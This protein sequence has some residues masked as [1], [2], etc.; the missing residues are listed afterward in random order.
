[1]GKKN[2]TKY[3][4]ITLQMKFALKRKRNFIKTLNGYSRDEYIDFKEVFYGYDKNREVS[5]GAAKRK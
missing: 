4:N 5:F 2:T 3:D 1:M